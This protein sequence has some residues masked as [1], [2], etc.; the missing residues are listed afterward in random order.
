MADRTNQSLNNPKVMK[1]YKLFINGVFPRTE[2]GRYDEVRTKAGN[3]V[4]NVCRASRKDFR[5]AVVAARKAQKGWEGRTAYNRSQIIYRMAEMLWQKE[6][7]FSEEMQSMGYSRSQARKEFEA[8]VDTLIYYAGWCDKYTQVFGSVNPVAS[9]HFNFSVPEPMGVVASIASE[10]SALAG[11]L[12]AVVPAICGANTVVALA[13]QRYPLSAIS[14][15]EVV[16]TSDV[17]PGVINILT[18]RRDELVYQFA[19]HMDV[20]AIAIWGADSG[21]SYE[22]GEYASENVK[23]TLFYDAQQFDSL[24]PRRIM[25]LQEI[26]TTWHPIELIS[27]S[28]SGY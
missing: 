23:R 11:F 22:I 26:K 12:A 25:D 4:A 3:L 16:A 18:G 17:P 27:G 10:D 9:P 24:S 19:S 15:A 2:S 28:G 6:S 1:T 8:S 21:N 13:S 20:N 5:N 7:L 14:F